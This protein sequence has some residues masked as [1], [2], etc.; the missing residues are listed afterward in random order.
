MLDKCKA[1]IKVLI[2]KEERAEL[3]GFINSF[4]EPK[5]VAKEIIP[6]TNKVVEEQFI[7]KVE[8]KKK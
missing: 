5:N 6:E 1:Q 3:Q 8:V 2:N 7:K 4:D